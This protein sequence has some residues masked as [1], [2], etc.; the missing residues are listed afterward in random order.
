MANLSSWSI[1]SS[2]EMSLLTTQLVET[3]N[4][5]MLKAIEKDSFKSSLKFVFLN[6][7]MIKI[8]KIT[9]EINPL[10]DFTRKS[11]T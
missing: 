1:S 11:G 6:F 8:K 10:L 9:N 3:R 5:I 4:T 7:G 2:I